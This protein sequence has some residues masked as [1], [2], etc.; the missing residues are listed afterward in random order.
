MLA[1]MGVENTKKGKLSYKIEYEDVRKYFRCGFELI[2]IKTISKDIVN[3]TINMMV[4][5]D[6]AFIKELE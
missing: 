3:E 2:P 6:K 5:Q 4:I 1:V